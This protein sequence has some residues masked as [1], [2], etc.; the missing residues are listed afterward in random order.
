M[1]ILQGI[2][3]EYHDDG[4]QMGEACNCHIIHHVEAAG[5]TV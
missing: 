2:V 1:S 5:G 3:T 4:D